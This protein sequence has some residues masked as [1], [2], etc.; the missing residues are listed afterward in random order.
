MDTTHEFL[1]FPLNNRIHKI[2]RTLFLN[3]FYPNWTFFFMQ[4]IALFHWIYSLL[5]QWKWFSYAIACQIAAQPAKDRENSVNTG[6]PPISLTQ[7]PIP[8]DPRRSP[9]K[10]AVLQGVQGDWRAY[11]NNNNTSRTQHPRS[12]IGHVL[13]S[14][15]VVHAHRQRQHAIPPQA[16]SATNRVFQPPFVVRRRRRLQRANVCVC[17]CVRPSSHIISSS[18]PFCPSPSRCL[19]PSPHSM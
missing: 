6:K 8:N 12:R 18:P 4:T 2:I 3:I 15:S 14:V 5:S 10:T 13:C 9:G 16:A 1:S 19:R 17:V 11:A 7:H